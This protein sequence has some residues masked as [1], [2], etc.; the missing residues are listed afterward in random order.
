MPARLTSLVPPALLGA[1]LALS[2]CGAAA[3]DAPPAPADT[4]GWLVGDWT[5]TSDDLVTVESWLPTPSGDLLGTGRVDVG[6]AIGFAETL[7][8]TTTPEGTPIYVAWPARRDAT[9]FDQVQS[10]E[11][12]VTFANPQHTFPRRITYTRAGDTLS[13]TAE[14]VGDD[15]A[16]RSESWSLTP[17]SA[18]PDVPA[19]AATPGGAAAPTPD[20]R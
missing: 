19:G 14:G 3:P 12:S 2:A 13:V 8:I 7:L 9:R 5:D 15:G 6:N 10:G 11:R 20:P 17:V 1:L 4:L 18:M 16:P